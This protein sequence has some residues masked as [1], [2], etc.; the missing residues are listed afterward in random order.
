MKR[1]PL[2]VIHFKHH[3]YGYY[4]KLCKIRFSITDSAGI[5]GQKSKRLVRELQDRLKNFHYKWRTVS[6]SCKDLD[7][8]F[9]RRISDTQIDGIWHIVSFSCSDS[10]PSENIRR[11]NFERIMAMINMELKSWI[12]SH[13][14]TVLK[15]VR[16]E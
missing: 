6:V 7:E 13:Y 16:S 15:I 11:E 2:R 9:C 8:F 14:R 5:S 10:S 3:V 4:Q 12:F 1:E